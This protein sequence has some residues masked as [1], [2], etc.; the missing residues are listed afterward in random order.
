MASPVEVLHSRQKR[1]LIQDDRLKHGDY[2]AA[3]LWVS[4]MI[5]G[6]AEIARDR[7]KQKLTAETRRH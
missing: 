5:A 6:I 4:A 1:P 3:R 2:C 7:E